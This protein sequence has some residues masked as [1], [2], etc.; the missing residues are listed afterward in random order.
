[1]SCCKVI[2]QEVLEGSIA[3]ELEIEKD[4]KILSINGE[5]VGDILE[6][7]YL[8]SDE[9]LILEIEKPDGEIWELEIEKEYDEDLGLL[10]GGII[11]EPKSCHN[12]CIF[13][14]IDQLPKGMRKTLYFKDDD[15]RLS[16]LQ[17]NFLSLTNIKDKDIEKI[18]KFRISP[19][20]ISV[21]TTDMELRKRML[22]N[23]NADKLLEYMRRL[24]EG[25]IEMKGQVVLC[26]EINDA[27][28]LEKTIADLYGFYP[29]LNCVAVVP[30]GLTRYRDG[31]F[32]LKEYN[33]HTAQE[34]IDQVENLQGK[35][36]DKI[37]TRFVF[38]SDEFY[39]IAGRKTQ[40]YENY[41]GFSQLENGVGIIAMFNH[42]VASSLDKIENNAA[43]SARGTILTGEYAMPVL[44]EA[45]N[46]IMY[47]L[48]GL[49]LDV[50]AIRNEFFGPSVRVSGLITG[51]DI[52]S[53]LEGKNISG[54]VFIPDNMLRSGETVFL[55]DITV[56]DIEERLGIKI[57]ICK[58]D[59][60]DLVSNIVEHCK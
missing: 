23:K 11:D 42:E 53:Q 52:I 20:N 4:D 9:F 41:E 47:K 31:L 2:I 29:E 6:Y 39:I 24:K 10:F 59:G 22:N 5:A 38:L 21:H 55:D 3:D 25:H 45:C 58:Q 28:Q 44:E 33:E 15:T 13:C 54:S 17:G 27:R 56:K 1:M 46:K 48:P 36:M 19:I 18:I 32:P 49:K 37:G 34:V 12:K 30:V 50:I 40:P 35:Y 16:F 60:R 8:I 43:M 51:G 7:K 57:I 14:F 26:P